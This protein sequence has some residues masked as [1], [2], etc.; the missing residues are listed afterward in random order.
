[1]DTVYPLRPLV[2]SC[3]FRGN[4]LPYISWF[5]RSTKHH[6]TKQRHE[7]I[8]NNNNNIRG[9]AIPVHIHVVQQTEQLS[10]VQTP[11]FTDQAV[12]SEHTHS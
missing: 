1:M 11:S 6:H 8:H 3:V 9:Q 5:P 7:Q 10:T 4:H 2:L 12:Q